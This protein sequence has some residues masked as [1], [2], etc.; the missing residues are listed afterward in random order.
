MRI[1]DGRG[2]KGEF[3]SAGGNFLID[4]FAFRAGDGNFL[5]RLAKKLSAHWRD[6]NVRLLDRQNNFSPETLASFAA[7]EWR[8]ET[9]VADVTRWTPPADRDA[10]I[11]ANLFLHHFED[12]QLSGLLQK[13]SLSQLNTSAPMILLVKAA[14]LLNC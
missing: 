7:L 6:V 1:A 4:D 14:N 9:I 10:V 13:I 2:A 12:S 8:A 5:L 3:A 11:V